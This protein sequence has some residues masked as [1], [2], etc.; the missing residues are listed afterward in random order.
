MPQIQPEVLFA[1]I[2]LLVALCLAM[3][4]LIAV[5]M[6]LAMMRRARDG[7]FGNPDR[8]VMAEVKN[9]ITRQRR[10]AAVEALVDELKPGEVVVEDE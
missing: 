2:A 6:G 8:W 10:D 5:Y 4:S 7:Q 9:R 1:V 3:G